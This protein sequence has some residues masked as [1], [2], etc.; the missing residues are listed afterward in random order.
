MP[1][2]QRQRRIHREPEYVSFV[3]DGIPPGGSILLTLDELEAIRLVDLEGYTHAQCADRMGVSRTTVSEIYENARYKIADSIVNGKPLDI[4][5]GNYIVCG[6]GAEVKVKNQISDIKEKGKDIMRIAVT[7]DNGE[8]FQHFGHTEQFKLYDIEDEK[9][10]SSQLADTNGSGHG[11]LAEFL[12]SVG[13][14]A[15]ICGGIGGGAQTAL[16]EKGIKLYGGAA[17]NADSA[18]EALLSGSLD[19]NPDVKCSHHAH[20]HGGNAHNC[21][22]HHGNCGHHG[23]YMC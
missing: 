10:K 9:V 5:G 12:V 20:E 16:A 2:P 15:L 18:V 13:A 17:G 19:Y 6:R 4:G 3:P 7:Y 11:E 23:H 8:I 22:N 21:M 14:D 1:R